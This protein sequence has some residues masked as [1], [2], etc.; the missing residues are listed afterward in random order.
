[1]ANR[2]NEE[3]IRAYLEA[4]RVHDYDTVDSLRSDDWTEEWPQS[5]ERVRGKAND[6]AI[7]DN[8]PGGLPEPERIRVV[9]SEDHWVITPA[10][11]MQRIVG[12]GDTWWADGVSRYPDGTRWF[13][14]GLFELRDGKVRRETWYFAPPLDPPAWRAAWVEPID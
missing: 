1:M 11:T 2:S 6:R 13:A 4:H 5:G 7:M 3:A 10:M 8:W 9:G 14:A 12:T